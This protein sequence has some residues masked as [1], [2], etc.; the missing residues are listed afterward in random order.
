MVKHIFRFLA[1]AIALSLPLSPLGARA[2]SSLPSLKAAAVKQPVLESRAPASSGPGVESLNLP[3]VMFADEGVVGNSIAK[4]LDAAQSTLDIAIYSFD[5]RSLR[6]AIT[7]A[8]ER[9][10]RV[11]LIINAGTAYEE[12]KKPS[13]DIE[14]MEKAGVQIRTLR[15]VANYYRGIQ[16]NKFMIADGKIM[17]SGSFNWTKSADTSS[18]ENVLFISDPA[19][20]KAF[21]GYFRFMWAQAHAIGKDVS[22]YAPPPADEELVSPLADASIEFNGEAF[23]AASFSP[24][25]K[26]GETLARAVNSASKSIDVAVFSLNLY[27]LVDGLIAARKRGA[28]V[29]IVSDYMQAVGKSQIDGTLKLLEAGIDMRINDGPS[30][31]ANEGNMH[32]KFAVFDGALVETGSYNWTH[33][34]E[35]RNFDSLV[36]SAAPEVVEAFQGEFEKLFAASTKLKASLI[37]EKIKEREE[38]AA[39]KA[40]A[41]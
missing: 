24:L 34:A 20:I 8:A 32:H 15:G 6:N 40:E 28:K 17:Q 3:P 23:P 4:V 30:E 5:Y 39:A 31:A 35:T 14:A 16:H 37:R 21:S 29:R 22:E 26:T 36:F 13:A 18:S 12:G 19:T 7:E 41:K 11:R 2:E 9:G 27:T 10:V 33:G 38:K 1:A 25:G